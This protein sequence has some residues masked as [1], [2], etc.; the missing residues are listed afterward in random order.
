MDSSKYLPIGANIANKYEIIDVLGEDEFEILYLVRDMHRKGSFF[1]LKELFL[2]TFSSRIDEVVFTTVEAIGVFNKRRMQIRE[3]INSQKINGQK[4]EI[5]I[6]GYEEFNETIYTIMEFSN[7]ADL[8]KYLQFMP[9]DGKHLPTLSEL[10]KKENKSK[11]IPF[12]VKIFALIAILLAIAFYAY[13][14]FQKNSLDEGIVPIEKVAMIEHPILRDRSEMVAL[15]EAEPKLDIK[16]KKVEEN[17]LLEKKNLAK[18]IETPVIKKLEENISMVITKVSEVK[19]EENITKTNEINVSSITIPKV[20]KK[21][22]TKDSI[23]SFLDIYIS[24]SSKSSITD[25]LKYYDKEIKRYFKFKN[26]THKTIAKSQ[27]R[28]NQKWTK[29]EFNIVDFR[30]VKTYL[31]G[32]VSYFDVKTTTKWDVSNNRGKKASGKSKGLM[33]LKEVENGFKIISIY[34]VK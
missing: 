22:P 12:F 3:E 8:E 21:V 28:Y 32:S 29:R 34:T 10:I 11:G 13:P 17:I 9:K 19:I 25:T 2:E 6:Y 1:V 18:N 27:E 33:T 31:E 4:N 16:E 7:N 26:P 14:Y 20:V 30:I 24:S 15:K 23:K 5:R